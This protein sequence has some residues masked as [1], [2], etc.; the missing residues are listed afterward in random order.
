MQLAYLKIKLTFFSFK[1]DPYQIHSD[2]ELYI[3]ILLCLMN[4]TKQNKATQ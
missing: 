4:V 2:T 3:L 1:L